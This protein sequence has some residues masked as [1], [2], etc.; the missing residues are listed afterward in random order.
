MTFKSLIKR[1]AWIVKPFS[2]VTT[3]PNISTQEWFMITKDKSMQQHIAILIYY[4]NI[5]VALYTHIHTHIQ[6]A[7][8]S[9]K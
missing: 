7:T 8:H 1:L 6:A 3:T 9:K 2:R 4:Y 5:I